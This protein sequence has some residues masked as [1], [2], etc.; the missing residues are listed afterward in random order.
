MNLATFRLARWSDARVGVFL[1]V[2][3]WLTYG[4]LA[5]DFASSNSVTRMALIFA[6]IDHHALAIGD[7]ARL[8]I[9]KALSEGS[10]YADKPPAL[11]F[12][13]LPFVAAFVWAARALHF[14]AQ[15]IVDGRLTPFYGLA[16]AVA[17]FFTGGLF[18]AASAAMFYRLARHWQASRS[19][20]LFG[21]LA[22]GVA[23]PVL[24]WASV[25]FAHVTA[26]ACLF[27]AFAGIVLGAERAASK[28]RDALA[29]LVA[30][31]LLAW[32]AMVE[33]TAAPAAALIAGFGLWTLRRLDGR[34][35]AVIAGAALLGGIAGVL[36]TLIYNAA[37][38]GS[39]F[40]LGYESVTGFAEMKRGLF[41]ITW[42]RPEILYN[43]IF[44]GYRGILW[45]APLLAAAPLAYW[46]AFRA[47]P[48]G[49]ALTLLGVP[50]AYFLLISG[51]V[52]WWGGWSTGPRYLVPSLAFLT[53][54]LVFL[55]QRS[56]EGA[57]LALAGFAVVSAADALACASVSM[58][59]PERYANPIFDFIL[60]LF[61]GGHVR[62][63]LTMAGLRGLATLAAIP[64]LWLAVAGAMGA[65][66]R[67]KRIEVPAAPAT[68]AS[69]RPSP[70]RGGKAKRAPGAPRG[71]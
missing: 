29:G 28:R 66:A 11:S 61:V 62:N 5:G 25:F 14:A 6:M 38:F 63:A 1:F 2:S 20:A 24:G 55:W 43:L 46:A 30:G 34:R 53:M 8:T 68:G 57:R 9:D 39:M 37:A 60:P 15:P 59:T 17:A 27:L 26:G 12:T 71:R 31:L 16:T 65:F 56:G 44:G 67:T 41:G 4:F 21:A 7:F 70:R 19:A 49:A 32:A 69:P 10:Y 51:F 3:L 42:P 52:Y 58:M 64:V 35:R 33:P 48:T 36:P 40:H 50:V 23:T 18:G 54:P 22:F 45:F 47:L 13:A